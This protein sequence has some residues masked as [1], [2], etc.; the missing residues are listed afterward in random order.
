MDTPVDNKLLNFFYEYKS[1]HQEFPSFEYVNTIFPNEYNIYQYNDTIARI[2]RPNP[3]LLNIPGKD[4]PLLKP[5]PSITITP[6]RI[7]KGHR[8]WVESISFSPDNRHIAS[9]SLDNTVKIWEVDSGKE[10]RKLVGHSKSVTSISFSENGKFLASGSGDTTVIV[11]DTESGREFRKLEGHSNWVTSVSFSGN[12]N[13]ASGSQDYTTR[14]FNMET[15]EVK[16]LR[17]NNKIN[18][19]CFSPDGRYLVTG[20]YNHNVLIWNVDSSTEYRKLRG[21]TKIVNSVCFS[22]D[23]RYVAS[24]SDDTTVR[25]WDVYTGREH[26]KLEGNCNYVLSVSFSPDGRYVASGCRD[27]TVRIWDVD[28]GNEV[29]KLEGHTDWVT[30]VSFSKNGQYIASGSRDNTVRIYSVLSD[31]VLKSQQQRLLQLQHAHY[32]KYEEGKCPYPSCPEVKRL[33]NHVADC[34]DSKCT[35]P[36]CVSSRYILSHYSKCK[37][38]NCQICIPARISAR[39]RNELNSQ[40]SLSKTPLTTERSETTPSTAFDSLLLLSEKASEIEKA[41]G[42]EK[43]FDIIEL[44]DLFSNASLSRELLNDL[45]IDS[46][47]NICK[48]YGISQT[49]TKPVLIERILN[50]IPTQQ[51]LNEEGPERKKSKR[52]GNKSSKRS[53]KRSKRRSS[54]RSV[55]RR[56]SR[57]RSSRRRSSKRRSSRRRSSRRSSRGRSS[58]RKN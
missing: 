54:R 17:E 53:I 9:G 23:G 26:R 4:V 44:P 39:K 46:L 42:I 37:D 30:S 20:N 58:R 29:S 13:I 12:Q 51:K 47:K 48:K 41:S 1:R 34:K 27:T 6:L 19:V 57:R 3:S 31:K 24:G 21:H 52:D 50:R 28:S 25:I 36:H 11:W 18:S 14:I 2:T 33:W 10:V 45:T 55:K 49:G 38:K 7:L 15:N 35:Y 56:S 32:C 40:P 5:N 43:V 8:G 22:L 16:T